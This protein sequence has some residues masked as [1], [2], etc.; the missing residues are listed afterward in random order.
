M[1]VR[2]PLIVLLTGVAF[3]QT[4]KTIP[5][6]H[7]ADWVPLK[8]ELPKPP[9]VSWIGQLPPDAEK[10]TKPRPP[11]MVPPGTVLL[12]R[13]K[14]VTASDKEP[15]IGELKQVADGDKSHEEGHWIE[16]K[17]GAQWVQIDLEKPCTLQAVI[18]WRVHWPPRA[19][20]DIIVQVSDDPLFKE[21]VT[22][23]FNN[24]TDGS[25]GL[26]KGTDRRYIET[27]EGKLLA[28]N[29]IRARYIRLYSNGNT[30]D[31]GNQCAEVEVFGASAVNDDTK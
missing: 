15:I 13:G 20:N 11:L 22:T 4:A 1:L 16:L 14:P 18:L 30:E 28:A 6:T 23:L 2:L 5:A 17:S 26:G 3:A 8:I 31:D 19:Y 24:D 9:F 27:I 29:G 10:P 25:A 7:P 21:N 12:S